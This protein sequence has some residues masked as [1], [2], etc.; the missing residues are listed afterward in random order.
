MTISRKL[1]S[2][3]LSCGCS[4]LPLAILAIGCSGTEPSATPGSSGGTTSNTGASGGNAAGGASSTV[5]AGGANAG[6]N[7]NT[8]APTGGQMSQVGGAS[9]GATGNTVAQGGAV[10]ATGGSRAAGGA[11]AVSGGTRATGGVTSSAGASGI[12]NCTA[13][14]TCPTAGGTCVN[15][16]G[17]TC[18][19]VGPAGAAYLTCDTAGT[20]GTTGAGGTGNTGGKSSTGG[21]AATGGSRSTGGASAAGATSTGGISGQ[22]CSGTAPWTTGNGEYSITVDAGQRGL[23]W[24]RF[25]EKGVASDHANIILNTAFGR[26]IQNAMKKGHDQAGFEYIRF[27]GILNNDIG[28]YTENASGTPV[29]NWARF[30]QVYDA[31]V[32]AGMRSLVEISFMPPA[33]SSGTNT[34]HWYNGVP[35]NITPAKDWT[36]WQNLM[37]A[38]VQH[39]E[40]RYGVD[41]VRNNWL[42]EV[43]NEPSWMYTLGDAGYNA[44]YG[45]TV[46]GL[47]AGD[48]QIKVG[49]PAES[50]GGSAWMMSNLVSY[51]KTN[52]LKLDF[53]S[54][55][56]YAQDG[57]A[58]YA[59]AN[60][61]ATFADTMGSTI[62]TSK[63]TGLNI[64]DE[65]GSSYDTNVVRDT[66]VSASF[67]AKSVHLIG[68]GTKYA[69][70]FMLAWWTL[71]DLYEEFNSG[72]NTAYREG[73]YGLLL[74]GDAN[75]PASFDV[76]KP[77]FNAFRLLHMMGDV[78]VT[79]TGG[80]ATNGVN[81]AATVSNDN[82]AV[83]VLVYN[84]VEGGAANSANSN[85]VKLTVNN[86]PLTGT[87]NVRHYVLDRNHSNSYQTWVSQGKP[88]K[89]SATQ[90]TQLSSA[91]EL[92]YY[93]TTSTVNSWSVTYPQ[94]IYG[95]SLF[96]LS[97]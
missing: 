33:L 91:A 92:C 9:T 23:A 79:A 37:A 41:E 36:K 72:T 11:G 26:N 87:I 67:I 44:L 27:H 94:N 55:H 80:N 61:M 73:N 64:N 83:Q 46:K 52:A 12:P 76:A 15:S 34:L 13:G 14:A 31:I 53:L 60:T 62:A 47:L 38:I 5:I 25:Y 57:T 40:A 88:A 85:L 16:S 70:P 56:N 66:E 43:W 8:V 68:T 51:A 4:Q 7:V 77:A 97:H 39:L 82:S 95:V 71:S 42:F 50:G 30:D 35:A 54:W 58:S 45:Y 65:W 18:L 81:V 63:F 17:V 32:A 6:G 74:K 19:C 28:L 48:A 78:R 1:M 22:A 90:W 24:S 59:N 75:V 96:V 93:S 21:S 49:G 10:A 29:Y 89:P 86:I 69:P 20:G 3:I 84:H 2:K